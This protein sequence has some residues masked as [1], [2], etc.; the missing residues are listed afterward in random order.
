MLP[1]S[2]LTRA[3]TVALLFV[4][5]SL[6]SRAVSGEQTAFYVSPRG[7]DAWT[8]KAP[9][10]AEE[11]DD[12]P[13]RTIQRARDA[14][15][16]LKSENDGKLPQPV[17]VFIRGGTYH[18][19]KPL[20]LSPQDSGSEEYPVTYAGYEDENP[21][22]SGGHR[23]TGWKKA[24]DGQE[25]LWVA[26]APVDITIRQLWVNGRRCTRARHP[27]Q[28]YLD[29]AAVPNAE[30]QP[31]QQG[32]S[33]FKYAEGDLPDWDLADAEVTVMCRWVDSHL[34]I[35]GVDRTNRFLEFEKESVFI[36]E[37]GDPYYVQGVRAA[38]DAPGEWW[39]DEQNNKIYYVPREGED[40]EDAEAV[41]PGGTETL[42]RLQGSPADGEYIEHLRFEDLRFSHTRWWFG[43]DSSG[44]SQ[45]SIG[46][47]AAVKA[48][49][50]RHSSFHNCRFMHLGTYALDLGPGCRH[51]VVNGCRMADMSGGGVKIG[52]TKKHSKKAL[53]SYDNTLR[54]CHIHHGGQQFHSAVGVWVGQSYENK[55]LHNHIHD[56]YYSGMSVGWSWG[57]GDSLSRDNKI[58][59]NHVHHIGRRSDGDGPILDDMGGIY[60]LG[61]Q[62][63]TEI[64]GNLFHDIRAHDYGGWGIYPD[65]G[66]SEILIENNVAYDT[67]HGG[68]HQHYGQG[69]LVR[70]NIF[71]YGENHQVRLS[72]LDEDRSF[73]F[74]NNIVY[75]SQGPLLGPG[76]D[77]KKWP[78][79]KVRFQKNLYWRTEGEVYFQV[80]GERLS[81][82]E[83][84]EKGHDENSRV[85]NPRFA[86]PEERNFNLEDDSPAFELGFERINLDVPA[87]PDWVTE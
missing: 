63:G 18:M 19:E 58:R 39:L 68:F 69:N 22:I 49:G 67:T 42:L 15:R 85:A 84:Q 75:Y 7:N 4:A 77:N 70:N 86:A 1:R 59:S 73:T 79:D 35:K 14:V 78:T 13:F 28:G 31:W 33:R 71:A 9:S 56:F 53:Q 54:N 25:E 57:Y 2:L 51:N 34:P 82:D 60:T 46:V 30:G 83:W 64:T 72:R 62:P 5:F 41:V 12:G 76:Y 44:F 11:G 20:T 45:A 26:P 87:P 81:F 38:L 52:D 17:T 47:P 21:V 80:G 36:L 23:V 48:R 24:S 37:S 74:R 32:Q 29:I 6:P 66:S 27:N 40:L 65:E 8:G 43:D 3:V 50:L 61:V 55:I 16:R 10:P